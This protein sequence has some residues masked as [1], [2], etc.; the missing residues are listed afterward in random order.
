M[1]VLLSSCH[2]CWS[3]AAFETKFRV[4]V[5]F[6]DWLYYKTRGCGTDRRTHS[7]RLDNN[8]DAGGGGGSTRSRGTGGRLGLGGWVGGGTCCGKRLG[9]LAAKGVG[10]LDGVLGDRKR[11]PQ[12][13]DSKALCA[14]VCGS[15]LVAGGGHCT[16][17][18]GA[19]PD[20][21][22]RRSPG[23]GLHRAG[24]C[25]LSSV[26]ARSEALMLQQGRRCRRP[27]AGPAA[28]AQPAGVAGCRVGR[29]LE[30]RA[31]PTV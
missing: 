17:A 16:P 19:R 1:L 22:V 23:A 2:N 9:R 8:I 28:A 12:R 20:A 5:V 29:W 30:S 31:H 27:G 26:S 18:V 24:G 13:A 6:V 10:G 7:G 25:T 3:A 4:K 11:A 14:G 21:R 15:A